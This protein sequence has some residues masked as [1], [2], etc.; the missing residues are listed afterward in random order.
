M[1]RET[2]NRCTCTPPVY[3]I[4]GYPE[5]YLR[6]P[7]RTRRH[8]GY[9]EQATASH[10]SHRVHR[11]DADEWG[12]ETRRRQLSIGGELKGTTAAE[13]EATGLYET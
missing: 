12:S 6:Q 11:T 4:Q 9:P 7:V 13:Y 8:L 10:E 2:T 3:D 1:W 5:Q